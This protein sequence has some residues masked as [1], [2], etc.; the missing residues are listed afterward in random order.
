MIGTKR[1][2][3]AFI[4]LWICLVGLVYAE[5]PQ[6]F[7]TSKTERIDF[8]TGG[9]LS[10]KN[11]TGDLTIQGWERRDVELT[12]TLS[13]KDPFD[14]RDRDKALKELDL[15]HVTTERH[16]NELVIQT[17]FPKYGRFKPLLGAKTRF[18]ISYHVNVPSK[19]GVSIEH[20]SGYVG[21]DGITGDIH[22]TASQGEITVRL[23]EQGQYAIDA[24]SKLGDV[25]SDFGGRT[26][27]KMWF[28]GKQVTG[29]ATGAAQKIFLRAGYGDIIILKSATY[30]KPQ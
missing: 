13:T 6:F 25:I 16:G 4:G 21:I 19:A 18:D 17:D 15:V 22:V 20:G 2:T 3:L 23:P 26:E 1:V 30:K 9:Q 12:T 10:L 11:S 27:R 5:A 29:E 8:P 14:A 7:Q 28:L 24:K